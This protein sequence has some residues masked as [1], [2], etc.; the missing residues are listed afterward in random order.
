MTTTKNTTKKTQ[1]LKMSGPF[2]FYFPETNT[3]LSGM[4]AHGTSAY[5]GEYK[6]K[7]CRKTI[8]GFNTRTEGDIHITL[9]DFGTDEPVLVKHWMLLQG[10]DNPQVEL[11]YLIK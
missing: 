9:E 6:G 3:I 2:R 4:F 10:Y 5:C 1:H 11:F 7:P 8:Y